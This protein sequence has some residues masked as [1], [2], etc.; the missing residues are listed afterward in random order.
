MLEGKDLMHAINMRGDETPIYL[1]N[2]LT[3]KRLDRHL[4]GQVVL[5]SHGQ[6]LAE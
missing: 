4:P 5:H 3:R 6:Q 2:L 1:V